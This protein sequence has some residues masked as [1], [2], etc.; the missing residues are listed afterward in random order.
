M[1]DKL[2][3]LRI[4]AETLSGLMMQ[5]A[6]NEIDS[7][8]FAVM[9]DLGE[10]GQEHDCDLPITETALRAAAVIDQ[11]LA[12]LKEAEQRE[13]RYRQRWVD[14]VADLD[15]AGKRN[16]ELEQRLQQ[17]AP[18]VSFYR[19][20]IIAAAKWVDGQR[21]AFDSENGRHD[22]DT[23]TFEFGN[24]AQEEHS[25]TLQDIADGIRALHP[26]A[27]QQPIKLPDMT[28]NRH[29]WT[30]W[31]WIEHV[32]GRYQH[33]DPMDYIEFGS[34]MAVEA[35]LKQFQR[36]V[37]AVALVEIKNSLR[38]QGIKVEGE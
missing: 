37:I 3:A 29:E 6:E 12:A 36:T 13:D 8:S 14:A 17:P 22:P 7:D 9:S 38:L 24:S 18:T 4:E 27:E 5:L 31:Q 30:T 35:M 10:N 11:L 33:G 32:G 1:S 19:D 28:T 25:S 2:E 20:G 23:G 15:V 26:Q 34:V 16:A 21:E